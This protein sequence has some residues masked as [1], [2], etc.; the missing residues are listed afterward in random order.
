MRHYAFQYYSASGGF[1]GMEDSWKGFCTD[2]S[3]SNH[4]SRPI[5]LLR[6]S[7]YPQSLM[8]PS[9][10]LYEIGSKLRNT[11]ILSYKIDF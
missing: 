4:L 6:N 11:A 7:K 5:V 2:E 9:L 8:G 1:R 3:F 10:D